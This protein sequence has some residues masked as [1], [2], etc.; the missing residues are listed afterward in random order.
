V[1]VEYNIMNRLKI[2]PEKIRGLSNLLI[3]SDDYDT[4]NAQHKQT[5]DTVN[6]LNNVKVFTLLAPGKTTTLTLSMSYDTYTLDE[7][8]NGIT[9]TATLKDSD[10]NAVTGA[11]IRLI[12]DTMY[13]LDENT[14][15][16]FTTNSSGQ[17][18]IVVHPDES[19]VYSVRA[20]F[21]GETTGQTVYGNS[22]SNTLTFTI[23]SVLPDGLRLL[24]SLTYVNHVIGYGL[25]RIETVSDFDGVLYDLEYA[26]GKIKYKTFETSGS[27]LTA[28]EKAKLET[29][30]T[31]ITYEN[32]VIK[33]NLLGEFE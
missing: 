10:N 18:S 22:K 17:V 33:Y 7:A 3:F 31:S 9:I 4:R 24:K 13:I 12:D 32:N 27:T 19:G 28:S 16:S 20:G 21:F 5:T 2:V 30:V 15:N 29:A 8:E 11:S 14:T 25:E 6:S 1:P 26:D 23:A